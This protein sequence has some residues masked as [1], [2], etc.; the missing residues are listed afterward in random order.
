MKVLD[1]D[2]LNYYDGKI[3]QTYA[4]KTELNAKAP[5]ASPALTGTP[6]SQTPSTD[7]NSTKIATTAYVKNNLGNYATLNGATFTGAVNGVT[8]TAGDNST[9]LATTAYVQ[10]E[11]ANYSPSGTYLPLSGGT[12]TGDIVLTPNTVTNTVSDNIGVMVASKY[13][14]KGTFPT[15]SQYM[16][17]AVAR[18]SSSI[19]S[20]EVECRYGLVETDVFVDGGV[21]TEIVAYKNEANSD[22]R[23]NIQVGFDSNGDAFA[24]ALGKDIA[25]F[26]SNN[27]LVFPN[28]TTVWIS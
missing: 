26:D 14:T 23:A 18:D 4:T 25:T 2:G 17:L 22:E 16:S 15:E 20:N 1:I 13:G 27:K 24:K 19:N 5:L 3:K 6:T 11:L 9:K 7:D 21:N 28:G 10:D 12:M 8:P